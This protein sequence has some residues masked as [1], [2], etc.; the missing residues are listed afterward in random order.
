[1][2]IPALARWRVTHVMYT[3]ATSLPQ[4][5]LSR[6][7]R[8]LRGTKQQ[9]ARHDIGYPV[10]DPVAS[11]A[12][13]DH[14]QLIARMRNLRSIGWPSREADFQVAIDKHFCRAAQRPREKA[15]ASNTGA[16]CDS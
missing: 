9:I 10:F 14:V 3:E 6:P 1:M 15:A 16:A 11:G 2:K 7:A 13:G 8:D 4:R 5:H 12:A